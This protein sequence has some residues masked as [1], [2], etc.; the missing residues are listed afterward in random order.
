V[1]MTLTSDDNR[2]EDTDSQ[3]LVRG[4]VTFGELP[5]KPKKKKTAKQDYQMRTTWSGGGNMLQQ[6]QQRADDKA[7]VGIG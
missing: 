4:G 3:S 2:S 6:A 7:A 1:P 5:D